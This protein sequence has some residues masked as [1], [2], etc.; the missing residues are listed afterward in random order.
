MLDIA[1]VASV[2]EATSEPTH[3]PEAA[4]NLAQQQITR[5]RGDVAAIETGHHRTPIYCFKF[6][7]LRGTAC[8]HRG[9]PSDLVKSCLQNN[10]I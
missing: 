10:F 5:V 4:I 2:C 9:H 6:E 3:K 8:L 1:R 7:Q